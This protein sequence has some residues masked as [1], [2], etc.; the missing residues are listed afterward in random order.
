M[1]AAKFDPGLVL[2]LRAHA[3]AG[4][5]ADAAI[6]VVL[7]YEGDLGPIEE[8]GFRVD[9]QDRDEAVGKVRFADLER[10]AAL[11]AVTRIVAGIPPTLDLDT[12]ATELRARADTVANIG[13]NGLWHV[14][15]PAG[16]LTVGGSGA[17]GAGVIVGVI[18]TGIDISHPSFASSILPWA[19]RIK[20]VWDQGLT[21]DSGAGEAGPDTRFLVSSR[22]YGVEYDT[23]AIDAAINN[24]LWPVF[25]VDFKHKDCE[26]HGTHVAAIAAGGNQVSGGSDGSFVGIAPQADIIA[27]KMLDTPPSIVDVDGA[28]VGFDV[29]FRDA[30]MYILRRAV[31]AGDPVVVNASFG[32]GSEP[33]DGLGDR[34][35]FLDGVFDPAQAAD[36]NHF[37]NGAIYVKSAGNNGDAADRTFARVTIPDAGEITVPYELFDARGPNT[38]SRENC[39]AI[40][41]VPALA[42]TAWYREVAAP[43]DVS[44]A[45]RVPNEAAFSTDVFSGS[46]TKLFDGG[47][48]RT[49]FHDAV[50]VSRPRPVPPGGLDP[51]SRNR[52]RLVVEPKALPAPAAPVHLH[53]IYELLFKGPPGTVLYVNGTRTGTSAGPTGMRVATANR[54]GTP[55]PGPEI[56][57]GSATPIELIDVTNQNTM[58]DVGGRHVI[59]VAAYDNGTGQLA[60]FSSRGPLRDYSDPPLGPLAAKPDISGPGVKINASLGQDSEDGIAQLLTRGSVEGNRFTEKSGTS[61]STPIISGVVALMLQKNPGLD[62]NDVR[63]AL[64]ASTA[65]RPG[66]RPAPGDPGYAE[67]FGP[68]RAAALESHTNTP[69]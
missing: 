42:V 5:D 22:T 24:S 62:V 7:Y 21:P 32:S 4:G 25:P 53:G 54:D 17:S 46:L 28:P 20:F 69:P 23:A 14:A 50:P 40:Q 16:T 35:R 26:G 39:V 27:V 12:A 58:F 34:D 11:P 52:I 56:V 36:D 51:V 15:K 49:I 61:M 29:R 66:S 31:D 19:S 9:W 33:G 10:I 41:F 67:A 60:E 59:S 65:G 38:R 37:P 3:E 1:S 47:K 57:A 55:L 48:R 8:A 18:D 64:A 45:V 13:T 2:A 43:Q 6:S 30:V 63:A 44:V 68:G